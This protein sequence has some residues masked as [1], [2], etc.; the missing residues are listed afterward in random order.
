MKVES[1]RR[2]YEDGITVPEGESLTRLLGVSEDAFFIRYPQGLKQVAIAWNA[3]GRHI[4]RAYPLPFQAEI[5]PDRSGIIVLE[6]TRDGSGKIVV[7]NA[8]GSERFR[9]GVPN[10]TERPDSSVRRS[11][12]WIESGSET[13]GIVVGVET[14]SDYYCELNYDVGR[15]GSCHQTK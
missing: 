1:F 13:V 10:P 3:D 12:L 5:L 2:H 6:P 9:L 14:G 7:V 15:F 8:D 11:F 4:E